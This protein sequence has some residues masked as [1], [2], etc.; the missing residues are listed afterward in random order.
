MNSMPD[1]SIVLPTYNG[2]KY[3]SRSIDSCLAQTFH[4]FELIIVNDCSTDNTVE[5]INRYATQDARIKIIHNEFNKKLPISLNIGFESAV[6]KYF[7]WT[8]DDNYYAPDALEKMIAEFKKNELEIDL[9]YCDYYLVDENNNIIGTRIFN[10]VNKAF[11]KWLG[12]GACFLYKRNIHFELNGYNP[13]AF[14]IEDYDFFTRAF[15]KFNFRYLPDYSV[16]YYRVHNESLTGTQTNYLNNV[17]KIFLE[18]NL[19]GLEKKITI[20]ELGFLYRK[21]AIYYAV[22]MNNTSKYFYYLK[23]LRKYSLIQ[24]VITSGFVVCK[25][26]IHTIT[27]G[28]YS[29]YAFFRLLVFKQKSD[30]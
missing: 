12:C 11:Y 13:A 3:I 8:S 24:I 1:I 9:V 7:T 29:I 20:K 25:K 15:I 14:L 22:T 10:D 4:D 19:N 27:I 2:S 28:G 23:K 6:G 5:I 16:Y 30:S 21:L 18:R 26:I 17:A